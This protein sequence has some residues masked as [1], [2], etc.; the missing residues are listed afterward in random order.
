MKKILAFILAA[1]MMLSFAAC[2]NSEPAENEGETAENE[3][4]IASALEL[5]ETVWN[6]LG[7]DQK[8]P[9]M[10]GDYDALVDGA[11]GV[12]ANA[13]FMMSNLYV[14]EAE[15]AN[16]TDAASLMHGMMANNFT[17]GAFRVS[18]SAAFAEAMHASF[19]ETQWLCGVPEKMVIA[20]V[21]S[22]YV[23]AMFGAGDALNPIEAKLTEAYPATVVVYN[24]AI[25]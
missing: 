21:G 2:G 12:V 7:E 22:E 8:F 23:V 20:T 19:A 9:V 11:P 16:V 4:E 5:L 1:M 24:E 3:V 18:D 13:D 10:G 6:S 25:A 17:C 14:P 15:I